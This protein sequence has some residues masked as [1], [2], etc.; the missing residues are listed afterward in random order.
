M[1]TI[2]KNFLQ[3]ESPVGLIALREENN[4]LAELVFI[5]ITTDQIPQ[6]RKKKPNETEPVL[7]QA[8]KELTE[9]FEGKRKE[10]GI[11]LNPKG[12]T[13]QTKVWKKLKEVGY[14]E[15]LSYKKLAE[16]A[17]SKNGARAVGL[18]MKSNPIPIFIPCHRV[19][20]NDGSIG[21]FSSGLHIKEFLLS[22]EARNR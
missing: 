19:L 3:I 8:A 20:K 21:G 17:G 9:Y 18:A 12:T 5:H 10:F 14:G 1:E 16:K 22:H 13:F 2:I 11:P 15:T 7:A 4:A 6:H